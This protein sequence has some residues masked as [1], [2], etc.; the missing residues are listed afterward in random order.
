M[1]ALRGLVLDIPRQQSVVRDPSDDS[2]RLLLL[3]EEVK[4]GSLPTMSEERRAEIGVDALERTTHDLVLSY[5]YFNAEQVLRR[6]LPEGCDVPGSFE[7]V[8]HI[9]HLNL[10][11]EVLEY[12]H[13]IGRVLLDKNPRLKTVVNKVGS[14]ESEFRVPTWEL[15]AGDTSLETEVRQHGIPFKLDFGEV[16]WN[17]RLEAEHKRLIEQIRPGRYCATPCA[18]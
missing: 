11:D 13:V 7:T 18:G 12:K 14:I 9:A 17:S 10:R 2:T 15:L 8:G 5:D 4:D 6:L 3:K 1:K 16:Y